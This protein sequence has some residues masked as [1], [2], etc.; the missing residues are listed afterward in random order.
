MI[1]SYRQRF[2]QEFSEE[3]YR[4]FLADCNREAGYEIEFRIAET[5]VFISQTFA[6]KVFDASHQIL[7]V[8]TSEEYYRQSAHAVPP[9]FRVSGEPRHPST[10]ALDFAICS[11]AQGELIP[12]LI[13]LQS[14]PS[15]FCYQHWLAGLYRRHFYVPNELHHLF[16]G[17]EHE[18]YL[19]LLRRWIIA[20]EDPNT[21]VLLEIEPEKQKTRVDFELTKKY[22]GIEYICISEVLREGDKLYYIKQGKK[23]P[24]RRLYNRVIFDELQRR[25]DLTLQFHLTEEV[26]VQW[27]S[28][29]NWF[30]RIS[31][32]SLPFLN[33]TYVPQSVFVSDLEHIPNDLHEYVLKPLFS[34]SGSGVVF[35]VTREHL[36]AVIDPS[37]YVLQRKVNYAPFLQTPVGGVK[38]ELRMLYLWLPDWPE[39]RLV[40][41]LMRLSRGK[42]IGV[43]YNR[44][45]TWVGG[46][47]GFFESA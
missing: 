36:S 37:N 31:K 41:N 44:N 3:K 2:N 21:V 10:I 9:E 13:E 32:Y 42:M 19:K 46:S 39:P 5:P 17:L 38:A 28:H 20:D 7:S 43:D 45:M 23:I 14:F 34:F 6:Q 26:D 1:A 16:G 29:P 4:A 8:I 33:G 15:L 12:Q 40:T 35:D 11:D 25:T 47:I 30:F 24:I 27:V 22:L 18:S